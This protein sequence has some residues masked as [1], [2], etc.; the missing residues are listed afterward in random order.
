MPAACSRTPAPASSR[1]AR[2]TPG[3][4]ENG[5]AVAMV[6]MLTR[7]SNASMPAPGGWQ[8]ISMVLPPPFFHGVAGRLAM[9]KNC[10]LLITHLT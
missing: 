10:R 6:A 5:P 2:S 1:I 8:T 3:K 7:Q 9:S 4:L